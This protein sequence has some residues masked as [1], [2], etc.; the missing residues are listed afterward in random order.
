M[1]LMRKFGMGFALWVFLSP[2]GSG[3]AWAGATIIVGSSEAIDCYQFLADETEEVVLVER[4]LL[5]N[6]ANLLLENYL[7]FGAR[8]PDALDTAANLYMNLLTLGFW[9]KLGEDVGGS[10]ENMLMEEFDPGTDLALEERTYVIVDEENLD[11][12]ADYCK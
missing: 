8:G 3:F 1:E 5:S 2:W 12:Q 10:V 7:R 11:A 4:T 6:Q 9:G